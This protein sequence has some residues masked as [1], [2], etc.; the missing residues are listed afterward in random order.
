MASAASIG[1]ELDTVGAT[2]SPEWL[3]K[4]F[5]TPAAVT[6][7]SAMPPVAVSD[8]D[9]DALTLYMLSL[10]GEPMSDYYVSMKTLPGLE[11]GRRLFVEKG[12]IGCHSIGGKGGKVGPPL[13]E[14]GKRHDAEW[15]IAHF[16][17]PQA[18]TPGTVMPRFSFTEQEIR[19]L[20]DFLL[21][22]TASS[23]IGSLKIPALMTPV[24]RGREV[25][26]K[27]GCTGCH[28]QDANAGIRNPNAKT[29][30]Q[31]PGLKFVAEGYT[32]DELKKRILGGQKEIVK[33]DPQGP[34]PPLYMPAWRGR[35]AEGELNDLVEYL[36]SL[37]SEERT[38]KR[39]F[40]RAT[41]SGTGLPARGLRGW[42]SWNFLR[43]RFARLNIDN[44]GT[45]NAP[46]P[47]FGPPVV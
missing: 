44:R 22:N 9:L 42:P 11:A 26:V 18:V 8:D 10:T 39:G 37:R 43:P 21:T 35:I 13:D 46:R 30:Q 2:R 17:N 32:K 23:V 7:G 45:A 14:V 40:L 34:Q 29:A 38:G 5:K 27:Y 24:E 15:I 28:G 12:C 25:F 4:H 19:A 36:M 47:P 6:P 16:R 3:A 31:V 41:R 20:T 1:P 33:L